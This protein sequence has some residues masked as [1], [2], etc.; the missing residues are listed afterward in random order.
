MAT[1]TI[2]CL[3]LVVNNHME[4]RFLSADTGLTEYE[5]HL[6]RCFGNIITTHSAG[7]HSLLVSIPDVCADKSKPRN[8]AQNSRKYCEVL[9]FLLGS[10]HGYTKYPLLV[11]G[12]MFNGTF[13]NISSAGRADYVNVILGEV[14]DELG[15]SAFKSQLAILS[16][17]PFWNTRGRFVVMFLDR[18]LSTVNTV[19]EEHTLI[20]SILGELWENDVVNAIVVAPNLHRNKPTTLDV[21][22][23][24]PFAEDHCRGPVNRTVILDRWITE[25]ESRFDKSIDLFPDK[26][27]NFHGCA[28][29]ASTF[30]YV[31]FVF[32]MREDANITHYT[33]G[34]E[35]RVLHMIAIA[36]NFTEKFLPENEHNVSKWWGMYEEVSNK[37]ADVGFTATPQTV[38]SIG[39]RD[40]SVWYLKETIRW[41]GPR[42][43]P[44]AH[45]K[46][47]IIIFTPLMWLL[48]LIIYFI[49]SLIFWL[50]AQVNS[51]V[52][53]HVTYTDA[54]MCFLQT[55]SMILGEAVCVRPHTW[56]LR[57]FFIIW[58][59]YCLLINTSYQSSLISVLTDPRYDPIVDTVQ[60]LL[61]SGMNYGFVWRFHYWYT[62][63]NDSLSKTILNNFIPCPKL[64]VCLRRIA[65]KQ[66]F[67]ICG[68]ESHLLYFSQ[69]K[70]SPLGIPSFLPFSEEVTSILVTM[71]F[72]R[73]SVFLE[74]FDRVIYRVVESGITQ[75]FWTD[76]RLRY[77]GN[78]D[79]DADKGDE[80]KADGDDDPAVV[81]SVQHLQSAFI[82][83]LLGL[84][85]SLSVFI[86]ELFYFSFRKS[87]FFPRLKPFANERKARTL[88]KYKRHMIHK[89]YVSRV[90]KCNAILVK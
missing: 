16:G 17:L 44:S 34:L 9:G 90:K 56:Y 25:S 42:A 29:S 82:L 86:T 18:N 28:V 40:H 36:L 84:A 80:G 51:A 77:V 88:V 47:L 30:A 23:W 8:S 72:H 2:L 32:P 79:E 83:L 38:R 13:K 57:L 76:I 52:K 73:G 60:K 24:F 3:L 33:E 49:C 6:V 85:C 53:E 45:W 63:T 31:P 37:K 81:L 26:L 58:V 61:N 1:V 66:D 27:S 62:R 7:Q 68:G 21:H 69:T 70:Y 11:A 55:F 48:V 71:F 14:E 22:T 54:L 89:T 67:A 46:S 10:I 35:I 43:K 75:K 78:V 4:A 20:R 74:S 19:P 5:S 41:F 39:N 65:S 15:F 12:P 59:F 64:D 87:R 50:L